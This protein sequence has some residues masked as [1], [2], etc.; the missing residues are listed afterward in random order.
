MFYLSKVTGWSDRSREFGN[1]N[2]TKKK[3]KIK[4]SSVGI[5]ENSHHKF[6]V[7][8]NIKYCGQQNRKALRRVTIGQTRGEVYFSYI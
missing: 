4:L 7:S 5:Y 2:S 3:I 8:Q 6:T 1:V